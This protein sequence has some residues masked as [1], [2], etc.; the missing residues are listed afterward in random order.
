MCDYGGWEKYRGNTYY[1]VVYSINILVVFFM[2]VL[3][4]LEMLIFLGSCN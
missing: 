2:V 3:V 4:F 1:D